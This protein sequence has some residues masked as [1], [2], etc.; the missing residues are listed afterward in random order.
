MSA[1]NSIAVSGMNAAMLG[2]GAAANNVANAQTAGYR[3]Q[4][5]A[6]EALADGGVAASVGSAAVPGSNLAA[7][8]V[9][10]SVAVYVFKA[11]V[12]AMQTQNQ[13]LGSLIDIRA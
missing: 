10:Q 9:Q 5:V 3:R 4:V 11:S 2:L 6:Q 12:R 7:D 1:I 13:L 8:S